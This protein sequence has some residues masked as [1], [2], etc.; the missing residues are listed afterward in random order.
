MGNIP[1][2]PI[3]DLIDD[4]TFVRLCELGLLDEIAVRNVA[5]KKEYARLRQQKDATQAIAELARKYY[6]S[7]SRVRLIVYMPSPLDELVPR[8]NS[9]PRKM[10]RKNR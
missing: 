10:R 6:R 1:K 9:K 7:F 2:N 3:C 5:I 4:K 8:K